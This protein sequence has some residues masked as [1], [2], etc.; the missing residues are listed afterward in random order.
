MLSK[1]QTSHLEV[2][3]SPHINT[4]YVK[5]C[6]NCSD[7]DHQSSPCQKGVKY[8]KCNDYEHKATE[9]TNN[10]LK[11]MLNIQNRKKEDKVFV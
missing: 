10:H 1:P 9:C 7:L 4:P 6:F 3:Q 2:H 8:F 5:R 11:K